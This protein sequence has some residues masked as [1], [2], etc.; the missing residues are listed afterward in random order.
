VDWVTKYFPA[1]PMPPV[2][3]PWQA[4]FTPGAKQAI[5]DAFRAV[6]YMGGRDFAPWAFLAGVL[7]T[8]VV[9]GL[10]AMVIIYARN[11]TAINLAS[12][13]Q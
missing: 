3:L 9:L 6:Y 10:F 12:Q 2:D 8:L 11:S 7:V 4:K 13:V 5:A 1:P